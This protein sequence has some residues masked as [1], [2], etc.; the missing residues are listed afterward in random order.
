MSAAARRPDQ[1]ERAH[2]R[3]HARP[4]ASPTSSAAGD[5]AAGGRRPHRRP[6]HA[7]AGADEHELP[8]PLRAV[9]HPRVVRRARPAGAR[10]D[11]QAAGARD[12]SSGCWRSRR[13]REAGVFK[14][15]ADF[16]N[17]IIGDTYSAENEGLKGRMVADIAAERGT[18]PFAT[19]IDIVVADELRTVLWPIPPDDD[20][21]LV[22][23]APA[24][25]GRPAGHARRLRRRR[26]PRPHVRRAVHDPLP[27]RHAARPQAACRSNGRC[28]SS[29]TCRPGCSA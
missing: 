26:P 27:R 11:R 19:L 28:S 1:L 16:A 2:R 15:L 3:L 21:A 14:R 18:E 29:P 8:E 13:R 7:G 25:V 12:A 23:A 17:Y 20:D 5:R 6:D 10:A 22:G 24:G 4:A 9:P